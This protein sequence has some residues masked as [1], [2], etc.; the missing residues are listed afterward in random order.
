MP[1]FHNLK[2]E[3]CL[4]KFRTSPNGLSEEE[5]AARLK[6]YGLNELPAAPS[7]GSLKIFLSQFASPL[8]YILLVAAGFSFF[9]KDYLNSGV[10]LGAV[11]I[12][13]LVGFF[14]ENKANRA[15]FKLKKLVA[16]KSIVMRDGREKE[17]DGKKI[18]VGDIIFLR[19]GSQ[20]PAD[21]RLIE[22]GN[23]L[24][25][26]SVLTGESLPA[27]KNP[28]MITGE[29]ALADR[30]NMIY[31]G[32]VVASG[33][34]KAVVCAVGEKT[35][36]GRI[37]FLVK[38]TND[39]K[40]P[41]QARLSSFSRLLGAVLVAISFLIAF[42]GILSGRGWFEMFIIAVAV[43]VASVPEGLAV[44]VTVVLILGMRQILKHKALVRK[45]A[46]IE[47]L[48]ST[49]VI[50]LDK[51]G[52]LTEGKMHVAHIIIGDEEFTLKNIKDGQLEG[53][54]EASLALKIGMLCNDAII[55]D[56]RDELS[57]WNFIGNPTETALLSA[58]I[59]SGLER[60]KLLQAE[61]RI[62][63]LPFDSA[64]KFMISLHR[65]AGKSFALYEKGAPEKILEKSNE[66]F[67]QGKKI[68][69]TPAGRERLKA[70]YKKLTGRGLRVIAVAQRFFSDLNR[71]EAGDWKK[72]DQDLTLVGFIALKDPLRPE[73]KETAEICR[74]A[75]LRLV[76]IT[77]DHPLTARAIAREIGIK[78]AA[79]E[80]ITGEQ[81][82]K[83]S[84]EKLRKMVKAVTIYARVSPHHKL[85]IIQ[86]LQK[87]GEVVAMTGDG[88]NDSPALKAA[89]I[90]VSLGSAVDVA[91][92]TS[93]LVLLD[94]NFKT[95]VAAVRQGRIIF[96]N[97]RKVI[98]YLLSDSFSEIILITG[99]IILGLPLAMLPT[100]ILWINII[101]DGLPNFSLAFEKGEDGVMRRPPIRKNEALMTAQ[102]KIIIFALSL[103]RDLFIFL[104]F[105]YLISL[106]AEISHIRTV[107]FAAVGFDSLFYIFSLRNLEKPIWKISPF[108]N[109][110]LLAGVG[111]SLFLMLLAIY[112]PPLQNILST[113]PLDGRSWFFVIA[114]A[115]L[116]MVFIEA[117]KYYFIS[118][119]RFLKRSPAG[120]I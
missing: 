60:E 67:H 104:I 101:N 13:T 33:W 116:S 109:P 105:F 91:K 54:V 23:L 19:P 26:E 63:E 114:S 93:D 68:K 21:A 107:I 111:A 64:N 98:T 32:T 5:A 38:T 102:M 96:V 41:L 103:I 100:Q 17:V 108:S 58:A 86:A 99:S 49:S 117:V 10:I 61:P 83:I 6:K 52:T 45:L 3:V 22:S 70:V 119:R 43:A 18:A 29:T 1:N 77:G 39:E 15:L 90:G 36:V 42:F 4:K 40:T 2:A 57:N 55:E 89:D 84:E 28:A 47:T 106:G 69:L 71:E 112:W 46:A 35:E 85:R 74:Q 53:R 79:R 30:K 88:V 20:I 9:L 113:K 27:E 72:I 110:W 73:A 56:G 115:L 76:I 14:Q 118:R 48:G 31:S 80:I 11:F 34:G 59:Q 7:S 37:A 78:E 24:V 95:I 51:T 94:N 62:D 82:E 75:G 65:Q 66:F 120:R 16:Y 97:L 25:N 50:C 87:N 8:I 92:E 12:N 81:L 44:A